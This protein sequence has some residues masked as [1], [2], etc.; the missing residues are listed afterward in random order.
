MEMLFRCNILALVGGGKNP[1]YPP[2][3]VMIWDD[4]QS[5]CIGEIVLVSE[6]KAVRLRRDRIVVATLNAV[7]VYNFADLTKLHQLETCENEHG[8]CAL[9]VTTPNNI[10]VCPDVKKGACK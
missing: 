1:R 8:L 5:R 7:S 4:K 9:C 6:V 10:L 3:K 2:N